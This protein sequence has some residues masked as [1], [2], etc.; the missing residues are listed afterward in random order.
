MTDQ[1]LRACKVTFEGGGKALDASQLRIRFD[2]HQDTTSTPWMVNLYVYNLKKETIQSIRKEYSKVTVEAG[3]EDS[4]G[5]IFSGEILQVRTLRE[6]ITDVATHII[7]RSSE[8]A[9]NFAVVN[10][11]LAAGHTHNDRVQIALD[12]M[13][14]HGVTAGQI[15]TLSTRKFSR[16]FSVSDMARDLLRETC[17]ATG[18]QW[19]IQGEKLHVLKNTNTLKGEAFV[20][21][22]KTGMIGLPEQTLDGVVVRSLLNH[23][24]IPGTKIQINEAS[25]QRAAFTTTRTAEGQ[26]ELLKDGGI[27][28]IAADGLYRCELVEHSGDTRGPQWYTDII[29]VKNDGGFSLSLAAQ[30]IGSNMDEPPVPGS[31]DDYGTPKYTNTDP[32][33]RGPR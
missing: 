20:L 9:R 8:K 15:D 6:N 33:V 24:I 22:S 25:I 23:K 27:L 13:K 32:G 7:A 26:N 11:S 5:I 16:G 12:A 21:N 4:S 29:C 1:Y 31:G 19:F 18:A 17:F 3:Y 10:K 14:E 30:G 2:T 28:G